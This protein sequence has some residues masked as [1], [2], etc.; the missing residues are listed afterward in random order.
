MSF[1]LPG[2]PSLWSSVSYYWPPR[3]LARGKPGFFFKAIAYGEGRYDKDLYSAGLARDKPC[4]VTCV[5]V[6]FSVGGASNEMPL[7]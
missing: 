1:F 3:F 2:L 4:F 7:G 5:R 6:Y